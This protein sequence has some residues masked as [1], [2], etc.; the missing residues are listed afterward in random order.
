MKYSYKGKSDAQVH[1]PLH[2]ALHPGQ[3]QFVIDLYHQQKSEQGCGNKKEKQKRIPELTV[4][5]PRENLQSYQG[6]AEKI[7][8]DKQ[9]SCGDQM[10]GPL[11][12]CA[13]SSPNTRAS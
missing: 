10:I 11:G 8:E 5:L 7:G 1:M 4:F 9:Y 13:F 2:G 3:V 6:Q 12:H